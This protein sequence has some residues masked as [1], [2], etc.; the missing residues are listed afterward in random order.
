MNSSPH[1]ETRS[2]WLINEGVRCPDHTKMEHPVYHG[3]T[4][5]PA[6]CNST[7]LHARIPRQ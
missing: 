2:F 5:T 4:S 3:Q 6:S 7:E 1:L